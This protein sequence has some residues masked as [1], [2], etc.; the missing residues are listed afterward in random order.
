MKMTAIILTH[1][2][3]RHLDR[4]IKS[5]ET[6]ASDILVVDSNSTDATQLIARAHGARVLEHRWL[7]YA[8][9][10]NWAL[11][12]LS[13]ET[14]WVL[15]LDADEFLTPELIEELNELLPSLGP[16]VDGVYCGRRMTFQ[17]RLIRHGGVFPIKVLRVF[18]ARKG[19]CE[20]RWMDEH[21]RVTGLTREAKGEIID[22]NLNSLTW[23]TTKHN[24][25]ASREAI[26]LLNLQYRFMTHDTVAS[27]N[28]GSQA[29]TK[30]W[31][32]ENVYAAMPGGWRAAFYFLYRYVVRLG[33]LDGGAGTAFHFLQGF[34]Y[35]YLVDA[36][37]SEVRRHMQHHN[38]NAE[39]AIKQVLGIDPIL[40][41]PFPE[42]SFD[43]AD[44]S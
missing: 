6:L 22:D 1:N 40:P 14:E 37:V 27:L 30:R 5:I 28:R 33:F 20:N 7:N 42:K 10:F 8:T 23:W 12:Q 17:G 18:R 31:L 21:I 26:D 24:H 41:K 2:E 34:W 9:Q 44:Q 32:K 15:R 16:E 4:C 19:T 29:S 11:A 38:C 39:D 25:Y 35:R 13:T 43:V 3:E 36:K